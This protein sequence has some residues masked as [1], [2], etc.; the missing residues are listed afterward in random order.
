MCGQD[1]LPEK[2]AKDPYRS[3]G[4]PSLQ[5]YHPVWCVRSG[6]RAEQGVRYG[7]LMKTCYLVFLTPQGHCHS[8]CVGRGLADLVPDWLQR[9][10]LGDEVTAING[11]KKTEKEHHK[12]H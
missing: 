9:M 4:A 3:Q 8:N 6:P 12:K 5:C 2:V 10:S 11:L 1:G 7:A